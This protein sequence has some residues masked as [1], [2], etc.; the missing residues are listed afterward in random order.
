MQCMASAGIS[1]Y[2]SHIENSIDSSIHGDKT[3][4]LVREKRMF[5]PCPHMYLE[6][7]TYVL[8]HV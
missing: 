1:A 4:R 8:V 7:C 6:G 5:E 2:R 3:H